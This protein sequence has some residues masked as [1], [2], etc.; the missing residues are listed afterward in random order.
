MSNGFGI[1]SFLNVVLFSA[2]AEFAYICLIFFTDILKRNLDGDVF[3]LGVFVLNLV[4]F[5]ALCF[6]LLQFNVKANNR[7]PFRYYGSSGMVLFFVMIGVLFYAYNYLLYAGAVAGGGKDGL[8]P[9]V[10]TEPIWVTLA[11]I[12]LVELVVMCL[13][14][15][16]HAARY[17]IRLYKESEELRQVQVRSEIQAL[18]TQLNPHF[19]FNSLNT[20]VSEIDYD[21]AAAKQFT[22]DLAGVYR[23]ILQKQNKPLVAVFEE[24]D[25]LQA[26]IN[27][28]RVRV[29]ESLHYEC[30]YPDRS[31]LDFLQ[32][33][34]L[35][36]L[37]LQLL[38]ENALK[39]NV[40]S[41][42]KPLYIRVSF[43]ENLSH[44]VVSNNINPKKNVH[45]LGTGLENLA[46][47]YRLLSG[48]EIEVERSEN[49]FTVKLPMLDG[50]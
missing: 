3:S 21:P 23:Y 46:K 6:F 11:L 47:R 13:I 42:L 41:G 48:Q 5:N 44:L 43:T 28:N 15:L 7:Y 35:P 4:A 31:N 14:T 2:L 37:S 40:I 8:S 30:V 9:F 39:H 38:V 27:L 32:E 34:Y 22:I 17:T 12:T 50:N 1:Y 20:L 26:Y 18:Q 25:F 33:N 16:N 49:Q 29:G 24:L 10:P 45:S 19:L 36:S